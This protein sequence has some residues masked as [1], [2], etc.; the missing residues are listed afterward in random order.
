MKTKNTDIVFKCLIQEY[1]Q[2]CKLY[3]DLIGKDKYKS[4]LEFQAKETYS[5]EEKEQARKLILFVKNKIDNAVEEALKLNGSIITDSKLNDK[6]NRKKFV[7]AS[8]DI[9][10]DIQNLKNDVAHIKEWFDAKEMSDTITFFENKLLDLYEN[11][12]KSEDLDYNWAREVME[13]VG[14]I[15]VELE[16]RILNN[17]KDHLS[18]EEFIVKLNGFIEKY[19]PDW[20]FKKREKK[21]QISNLEKNLSG[22]YNRHIRDNNKSLSTTEEMRKIFNSSSVKRTS[23][24][25]R[26]P[27]GRIYHSC[28]KSLFHINRPIDTLGKGWFSRK[29]QCLISKSL[30]SIL[31]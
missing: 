31:H 20:K 25:L 2:K 9:H 6:T 27:Y 19:M 8:S 17:C 13:D 14:E 10:T 12:P 7:N 15:R 28:N 16:H 22:W 18:I 21:K 24:P 5:S 11:N 4:L 26:S 23:Y 29:S 30:K 1:L 3:K